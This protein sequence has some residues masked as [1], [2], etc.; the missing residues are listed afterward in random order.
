MTRAELHGLQGFHPASLIAAAAHLRVTMSRKRAS[1]DPTA[2]INNEG[3]MNGYLDALDDLVA[4]AS[5]QPPK[6]EK[7]AF[8]PYSQ[9][10][11]ETPNKP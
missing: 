1:S 3:R 7:A 9:P 8:Q 11:N 6:P 10:Q 5:Q 4:A 2:I